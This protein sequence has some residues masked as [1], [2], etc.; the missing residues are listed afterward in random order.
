MLAAAVT[1]AIGRLTGR[2][3]LRKLLGH[4]AQRLERQ[5][6]GRSVV[7][8]SLIRKVPIAPFS[9]INML[10]G[11]SG[12]SFREFML[13]T[14]IGMLPGIA[15]FA[16]AGA[17]FADVWR[18]PTPAN[19]AFAAGAIALWVGVVWGVQRL[20]NRYASQQ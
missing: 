20:I 3:P 8:V 16:L 18:N 6:K 15:A 1:F 5:L 7:A 17:R 4:R 9:I 13:G 14:A 11:A 10:I 2:K 19:L 12:V